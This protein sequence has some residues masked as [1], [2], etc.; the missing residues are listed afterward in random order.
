M[1]DVSIRLQIA[2]G[3]WSICIVHRDNRYPAVGRAAVTSLGVTKSRRPRLDL[4]LA[5]EAIRHFSYCTIEDRRESNGVFAAVRSDG[6][7]GIESIVHEEP[8]MG[9]TGE[10]IYFRHRPQAVRDYRLPSGPSAYRM[11]PISDLLWPFLGPQTH[12]GLLAV[13][14]IYTPFSRFDPLGINFGGNYRGF[15]DDSCTNGR[16][17]CLLGHGNVLRS[18]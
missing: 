11:N 10:S 17:Q 6:H 13:A 16:I 12:D 4:S 9:N 18:D 8:F 1:V 15:H 14:G 7:G 5:V 2:E 3:D